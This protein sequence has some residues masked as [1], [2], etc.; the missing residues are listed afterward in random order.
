MLEDGKKII[1]AK[2]EISKAMQNKEKPWAIDEAFGKVFAPL[3]GF[4]HY[5]AGFDFWRK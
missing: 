3:I 1:A 5:Q 4:I 2:M